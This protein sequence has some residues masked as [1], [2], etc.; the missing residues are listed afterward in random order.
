M[1]IRE[2]GALSECVNTSLLTGTC[3]DDLERSEKVIRGNAY[4][5]PHVMFC[6]FSTS[7]LVFGFYFVAFSRVAV[8]VVLHGV[9]VPLN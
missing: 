3:W 8:L 1:K 7:R 5:L 2:T 9:W 4:E 6:T